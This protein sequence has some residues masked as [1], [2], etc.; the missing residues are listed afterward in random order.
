MPKISAPTVAAHRTQVRERILDA[1]AR[2]TRSQGID[3]IS[4]T[5]VAG[6]A[7][8]TRT[9]LYNYFPD[10]PSLL[11]AFTEHVTTGF[12]ER[13]RRQLPGDAPAPERLS[14]FVRLQLEGLLEHPHPAAAE[15]S[16][17]LGPDAYQELADHVAPMKQLLAEIVRQGADSGEFDVT[18]APPE[19]TAKLTLAMIGGQRVPLLSGETNIDDAHA[20]VAIFTLR[21]LGVNMAT[22][23]RATRF[24]PAGA[25]SASRTHDA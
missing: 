23:E 21:A 13:F 4:L 25:Y 3:Q 17:S 1:V 20:L 5:D 2:L 9:A 10:K 24:T 11:L 19:A 7:G 12:V 8:I 18:A 15:L 16:A 22:A 14:A 6:E